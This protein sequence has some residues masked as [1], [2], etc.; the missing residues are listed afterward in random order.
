MFL[1]LQVLFQ[2]I[3]YAFDAFGGRVFLKFILDVVI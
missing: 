1:F 3:K 2:K